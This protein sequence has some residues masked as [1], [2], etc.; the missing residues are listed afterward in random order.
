MQN[1]VSP[2]NPSKELNVHM[3]LLFLSAFE[4]KMANNLINVQVAPK[5]QK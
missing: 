3:M 5:A 2:N 4:I 1:Q